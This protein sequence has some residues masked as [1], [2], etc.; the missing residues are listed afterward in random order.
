MISAY[1][2]RAMA[3]PYE[4]GYRGVG[5]GVGVLSVTARRMREEM[6]FRGGLLP[7]SVELWWIVR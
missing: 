2:S 3:R 6:R 5:E 7:V 4:G 1:I